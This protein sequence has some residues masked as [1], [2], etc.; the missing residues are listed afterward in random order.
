MKA[1]F[2]INFQR[3]D[4][5]EKRERETDYLLRMESPVLKRIRT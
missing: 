5:K 1:A 4:G 2:E 3:S